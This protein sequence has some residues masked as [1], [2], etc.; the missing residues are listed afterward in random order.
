MS[1]QTEE[2]RPVM[3]GLDYFKQLNTSWGQ[4][5]AYAS[6]ITIPVLALFIAFQRSF[7]NSIAS[8]GVKG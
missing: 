4:I 5:M 1:V 7:I 8:S 2:L 3:V 6:L